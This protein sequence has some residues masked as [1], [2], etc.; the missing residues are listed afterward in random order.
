MNIRVPLALLNVGSVATTRL[1]GRPQ[2]KRPIRETLL[3]VIGFAILGLLLNENG[4]RMG[5][6]S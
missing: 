3:M 1:A 6:D 5:S 4:V 2:Q